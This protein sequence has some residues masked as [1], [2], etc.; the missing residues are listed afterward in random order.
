MITIVCLYRMTAL[1]ASV[2]SHKQGRGRRFEAPY[3]A[4]YG[5]Q[6]VEKTKPSCR[7]I[8]DKNEHLS[9]IEFALASRR[10]LLFASFIR[11]KNGAADTRA[12][13]VRL[14][15]AG[16]AGLHR[17]RVEDL[18]ANCRNCANL[19]NPNEMGIEHIHDSQVANCGN[20]PNLQ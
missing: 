2:D 20:R 9:Y 13:P 12:R 5:T 14:R 16:Q 11:D 17:Q 7:T 15:A 1:L 6:K 3:R 18:S 19:K 4:L 8:V 10:A